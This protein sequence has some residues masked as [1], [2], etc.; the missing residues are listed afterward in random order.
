MNESDPSAVPTAPG[1]PVTP[2]LIEPVPSSAQSSLELKPVSWWLRKLFACNPF[3]L[4]SAALLLFGCYRVSID[5]PMFNLETA[6]LL[7]NF[8]AVQIYEVLLVFTA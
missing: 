4:V 6:R 2:P 8:T 1:V 3:Y 5:A 7:F